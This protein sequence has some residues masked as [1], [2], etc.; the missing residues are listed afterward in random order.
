[1]GLLSLLAGCFGTKDDYQRKDGAWYWRDKVIEGV[2]AGAKLKQLNRQFAAGGDQ[3]F[4]QAS[5]IDGADGRTSSRSTTT[6]R[7]M[8]EPSTTATRA[9]TAKNIS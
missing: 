4:F 6:T 8:L 5:A 2:A 1:M 7:R 3:A 9:A